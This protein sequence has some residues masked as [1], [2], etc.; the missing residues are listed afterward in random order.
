[1]ITLIGI[2]IVIIALIICYFL[3]WFIRVILDHQQPEYKLIDV[4]LYTLIGIVAVIV[5]VVVFIVG[6]SIGKVL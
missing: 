1:M 5:T 3:G 4:I 2:I 6:R